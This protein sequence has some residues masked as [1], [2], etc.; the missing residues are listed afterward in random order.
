M[1]KLQRWK[2]CWRRSA[3]GAGQFEGVEQ[4]VQARRVV[5]VRRLSLALAAMV[6]IGV[7]VGWW[8]TRGR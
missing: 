8:W 1:R 6:L 4:V 3:E 5:M 7:A 2:G